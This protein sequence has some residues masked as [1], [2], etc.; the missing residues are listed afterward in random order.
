MTRAN[1]IRH[2]FIIG[3]ENITYFE[4]LLRNMRRICSKYCKEMNHIPIYNVVRTVLLSTICV[5]KSFQ[6][7]L[8]LIIMKK[9]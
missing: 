6:T 8:L 1:V 9:R 2:E 3:E 4:N 5:E 7:E